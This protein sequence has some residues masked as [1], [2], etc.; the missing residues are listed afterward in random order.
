MFPVFV[1]NQGA[2]QLELETYEHFFA[3]ITVYES[4]STKKILM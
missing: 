3:I 1:D 2:V 4:L